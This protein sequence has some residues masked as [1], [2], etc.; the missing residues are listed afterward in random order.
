MAKKFK[1]KVTHERIPKGT[2]LGRHPKKSSMNK[3]K[4]RTY[5]KYNRQGS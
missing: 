2:S 1:D 5:K 3:H 4:R